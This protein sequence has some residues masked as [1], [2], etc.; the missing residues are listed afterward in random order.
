MRSVVVALLL[1]CSSARVAL[2]DATLTEGPP[3]H[4]FWSFDLPAGYTRQQTPT[5]AMVV[6]IRTL[7]GIVSADAHVYESSDGDARLVVLNW[8]AAEKSA[9][10]WR[11]LERADNSFIDGCL[12][13]FDI[14]KV[15]GS[16]RQEGPLLLAETVGEAQG[17]YLVLRRMYGVDSNHV[18]YA[19]HIICGTSDAALSE[20]TK[21]VQSMR[22]DIPNQ[23]TPKTGGRSDLEDIV[24]YSLIGLVVVGGLVLL[25][26]RKTGRWPKWIDRYF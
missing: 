13:R 11:E 21:I 17:Q 24:V 3:P 10:T 18:T 14:K 1:V 25:F 9:M 19:F 15:S 4:D 6:M 12:K 2:G 20:C 8:K 23:V 26:L 16:Q 5:D 7:P 22:V